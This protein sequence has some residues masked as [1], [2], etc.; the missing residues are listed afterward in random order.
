MLSVVR[1]SDVRN[2]GIAA[3]REEAKRQKQERS[4]ANNALIKA[5]EALIREN[6]I[7]DLMK[8]YNLAP[9]NYKFEHR[10]KSVQSLYDKLK[11][12]V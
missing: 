7:A 5:L 1:E 6:Q 9:D 2:E 8:K 11:N 4:E 10:A 12:F 3:G